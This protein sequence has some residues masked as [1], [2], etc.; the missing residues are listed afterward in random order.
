MLARALISKPDLL[1]FD[2]P[3]Q[4]I[5]IAGQKKLN[6][7]I[8]EI[9]REVGCGV[10]MISHDLGLVV[11]TADDVVVLVPHEYEDDMH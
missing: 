10:L 6:A 9:Y 8:V 3:V 7:L 4:G 1:V 11:D 2:E 5:D